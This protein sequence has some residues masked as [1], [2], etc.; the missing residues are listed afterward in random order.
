MVLPFIPLDMLPILE[1]GYV[2]VWILE[3]LIIIYLVWIFLRAER[4]GF[5]GIWL[6]PRWLSVAFSSDTLGYSMALM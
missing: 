4:D 3:D 1:D 6:K 5:A 2:W